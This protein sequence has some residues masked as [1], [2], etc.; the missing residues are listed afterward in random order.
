VRLEAQQI[1]A[2][3]LDADGEPAGE[4]IRVASI[5]MAAQAMPGLYTE[6]LADAMVATKNA[7]YDL[8]FEM[9]M[10][11]KGMKQLMRVMFGDA[12]LWR[13]H[14]FYHKHGYAHAPRRRN[15]HGRT[16]VRR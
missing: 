4:P 14:N 12:E 10:S 11:A 13:R 5:S 8:S 16:G 6:C 2:Q 15:K 7:M 9:K 1:R 3:R